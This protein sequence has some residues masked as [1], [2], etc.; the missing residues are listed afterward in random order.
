MCYQRGQFTPGEIVHH[1]I[2]LNPENVKDPSISLGYNNLMLLCRNCHAEVHGEMYG[3]D[4]RRYEIVNGR[5][6]ARADDPPV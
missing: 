5:V 6:I 3:H 2:H 1:K 4:K